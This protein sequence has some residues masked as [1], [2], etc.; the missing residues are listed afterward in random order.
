MAV[1]IELK[2]DST[3]G[4]FHISLENGDFKT[5]D[6]FDTSLTIALFGDQRADASEVP[7]AENR[8]GWWGNEVN[9]EDVEFQLGSKLWLLEQSRATPATLNLAIGYARDATQ[10]LVD[11][12]FAEGIEI[13]GKIERNGITLT[14]TIL[15][16][17]GVTET[18]YFDLWNNTGE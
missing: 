5:V 11:D 16:N 1:D 9:T 10:Y 12:G 6:S 3:T 15:R 18:R 17:S 13:T 7:I 2:Q 4:K 8:R 14:I